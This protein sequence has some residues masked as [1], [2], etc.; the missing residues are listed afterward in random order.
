VLLAWPLQL[1]ELP[2]NIMDESPEARGR[3]L[4]TLL[5]ARLEL[6]LGAVRP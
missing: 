6:A 4:A 3:K 1:G 2:Q 5:A